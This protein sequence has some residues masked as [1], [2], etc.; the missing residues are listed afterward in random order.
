MNDISLWH[1]LCKEYYRL[2]QL[3]IGGLQNYPLSQFANLFC[4]SLPKLIELERK[5]LIRLQL[6]KVNFRLRM[7]KLHE[8]K[9]FLALLE[10]FLSCYPSYITSFD[11]EI[12]ANLTINPYAKALTETQFEN[13]IGICNR[14]GPDY[15]VDTGYSSSCDAF[16]TIATKTLQADQYPYDYFYFGI[17][18][19]LHEVIKLVPTDRMIMK[20]IEDINVSNYMS[21]GT[22]LSLNLLK[23]WKIHLTKTHFN[24][25]FK[26]ITNHKSYNNNLPL[27]KIYILENLQ[28]FFPDKFKKK[29]VHWLKE[30]LNKTKDECIA[31]LS[32]AQ[33]YILTIIELNLVDVFL[34][35]SIE[36]LGYDHSQTCAGSIFNGLFADASKVIQLEIV[37]AL[38]GAISHKYDNVRNYASGVLIKLQYEFNTKQADRTID[39]IIDRLRAGCCNS[40]ISVNDNS[41]GASNQDFNRFELIKKSQ[42]QVSDAK[43]QELAQVF[44]EKLKFIRGYDVLNQSQIREL[45]ERDGGL[46]HDLSKLK[47]LLPDDM[48]ASIIDALL[49]RLTHISQVQYM[50]CMR[51][52]LESYNITQSQQLLDRAIT[53]LL[54][55]ATSMPWSNWNYHYYKVYAIIDAWFPSASEEIKSET[56][57]QFVNLIKS[58]NDWFVTELIKNMPNLK[59]E[60]I[61]LVNQITEQGA[62]LVDLSSDQLHA[63]NALAKKVMPYTQ[64]TYSYADRINTFSENTDDVDSAE[65]LIS[66]RENLSPLLLQKLCLALLKKLRDEEFVKLSFSNVNELRLFM[67]NEN[68]DELKNIFMSHLKSVDSVVFMKACTFIFGLLSDFSHD[69]KV[70][71][72]ATLKMKLTSQ[73]IVIARMAYV[74]TSNIINDIPSSE[75]MH[76]VILAL[77]GL[78]IATDL[79]GN[80]Y[81]KDRV[82]DLMFSILAHI[83]GVCTK[84][85]RQIILKELLLRL[86]K[87]SDRDI[88]RSSILHI[89]PHLDDN[90]TNHLVYGFI[91]SKLKDMQPE[92]NLDYYYFDLHHIMIKTINQKQHSLELKEILHNHLKIPDLCDIAFEYVAPEPR[93]SRNF[94]R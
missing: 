57:H 10:F 81:P 94:W 9:P 38:L 68:I 20:V 88:A 50:P 14:I 47:Y 33:N 70:S 12:I 52:I 27:S 80:L 4:T 44:L 39:Y 72:Y 36:S 45:E 73:D 6:D 54:K 28:P 61:N 35:K 65:F 58:Q 75:H 51:T 64:D 66:H 62:N 77:R 2:S 91:L 42:T 5:K 37:D 46:L 84:P 26:H 29:I 41:S 1:E 34:R 21:V 11:N 22:L 92:H 93:Y 18:E 31:A 13:I 43:K 48:S 49:L 7:V 16:N 90:D 63:I 74:L 30:Q 40:Y 89:V 23:S 17:V 85:I 8:V 71:I 24:A 78:E 87:V 67:T 76:L 60:F 69:D 83:A 79:N 53:L 82:K 15:K 19:D 25:V 86:V 3:K 55:F 56:M 59:K 32:S